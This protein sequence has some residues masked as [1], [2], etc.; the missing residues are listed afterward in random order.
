MILSKKWLNDYVSIAVGDKEFS[1]AMTMSGSKVEGYKTEGSELR[2]IVVGQVLSLDKHPDSDHLWVCAVDAGSASPVQIVTGA[3]NVR[4]HDFVPVALDCSVVVGGKEIRTGKIRGV[5]SEGMFC[6]L[7]ELGLTKHDFPYAVEDGIFIL[8][9]DCARKPGA[10]IRSAI[11]LNDTVVEFEITSNRPDCL[12]VLG[13]AREAAATFHLPLRAPAPKALKGSGEAGDILKVSILNSDKCYRYVGAVVKNVQ[14]APSP[15]WI[16]ERLRASGVR[17]INN[18]V[19]ITNFVMLEFGQPMHAFDIRYL[20]GSEVVVRCAREGESI[21]TLD[22]IRRE[23]SDDMLVIADTEKPVAVAGVMG[24][25]YSGIMD[26]TQT[27]VFESACFNGASVRQ[28]A[29]K[30]G[31]RTES[32]SRFEK[33]LDPAGCPVSMARALE[34]VELLRAGEVVNGVVD[35]SVYDREPVALPFDWQWVNEFI[36]IDIPEEEQ[37]L[38]L[39]KLEFKVKD[40][41][42]TVPSFRND[43]RHLADISE[44]IARFYGYERIPGRPLTG[45]AQ[46]KLTDT[47]KLER[48]LAGALIGCGFSEIHT[49]SFIS[50]KAYDKIL[51]PQN[52]AMR[53]SVVISNPLGEDTSVMRTTPLPSMLDVLERNYS[54]RNDSAKLFELATVYIPNGADTLPEELTKISLG[55]YGPGCDFFVLKGAVEELLSKA[56]VETAETQPVTDNPSFHPGRCAKLIADNAEFAVF[57]E[58]HPLVAENYG[59]DTRVYCACIDFNAIAKLRSSRKVYKHLPK[60]PPTDRD[61]AFVCDKSITVLT[62]EKAIYKAAGSILESLA[63]FDVYEGSQIPEGKKSVAFNLRMRSSDR[64]LKDEE[65]DEVMARVVSSL[66]GL[67]AFLRS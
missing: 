45:F 40:G 13:L 16:R 7:A 61:I 5:E 36:G 41:V 47:Q 30:L 44:E 22:G 21:T 48:D 54:R 17:P 25:E 32:S 10:E 57:G 24:G 8:G 65:A 63:L 4:Q 35:C 43:V 58:I 18:I 1:D 11:G 52:S 34:L 3:Q 2:N 60:F 33:E 6:S 51:L 9:D 66:G 19:D 67:G 20:T 62:L 46:G 23:L 49:Y 64:T 37:K 26:D 27:I 28:T 50:P 14:I 38:I 39:E 15:L 55:M 59:L 31:M 42:V 12:S 29:K 53:D 56:G